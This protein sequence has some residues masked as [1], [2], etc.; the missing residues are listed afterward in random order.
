ML[1]M[2][3]RIPNFQDLKPGFQP[4][5]RP[6]I[7]CLRSTVLL[8][9]AARSRLVPLAAE[10]VSQLLTPC[11]NLASKANEPAIEAVK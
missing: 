1:D 9:L 10:S 5:R 11:P 4:L 2:Y 6:E 7:Y 8:A 3:R